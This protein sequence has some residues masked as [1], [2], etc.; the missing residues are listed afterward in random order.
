M[1]GKSSEFISEEEKGSGSGA[2]S[3]DGRHMVG[4]TPTTTRGTCSSS[5]GEI[6]VSLKLDGRHPP[7][8]VSVEM[9]DFDFSG[10]KVYLYLSH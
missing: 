1:A 3:F 9:S 8:R 6:D 2:A 10:H 4:R 5:R 7:L